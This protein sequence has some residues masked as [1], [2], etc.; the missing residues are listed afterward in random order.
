MLE[1]LPYAPRGRRR[2]WTTG[3]LS[4]I[5]IVGLDRGVS[6]IDIYVPLPQQADPAYTDA[7]EGS[8]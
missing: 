2:R 5:I 3:G 6:S 8:T 4:Q 7:D 1:P